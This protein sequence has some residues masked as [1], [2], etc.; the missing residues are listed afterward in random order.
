MF[1]LRIKGMIL[2]MGV[3]L[4]RMIV[5]VKTLVMMNLLILKDLDFVIIIVTVAEKDIV[6]LVN[7]K[8]PYLLQIVH[9]NLTITMKL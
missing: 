8:T 6:F 5:Q 4:N 7:V 1:G 2:S 9:P 3:S